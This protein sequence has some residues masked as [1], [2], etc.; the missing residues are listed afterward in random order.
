MLYLYYIQALYQLSVLFFFRVVC[1]SYSANKDLKRK[2]NS[3][4]KYVKLYIPGVSENAK[5]EIVKQ[6]FEIFGDV[7]DVRIVRRNQN[8]DK[9]CVVFLKIDSSVA[10]YAI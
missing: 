2:P 8:S 4:T 3:D 10:E 1:V 9:T 6:R 5:E 7:Q